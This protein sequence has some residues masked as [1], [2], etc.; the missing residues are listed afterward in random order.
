MS[1]L[2]IALHGQKSDRYGMA[3]TCDDILKKLP[4]GLSSTA[5]TTAHLAFL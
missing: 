2:R 4:G 5:I 3:Q 1:E